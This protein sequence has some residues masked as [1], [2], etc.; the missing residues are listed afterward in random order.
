MPRVSIIITS[1]NCEN[2][3]EETIASAVAQSDV[4]LEVIVIDDAST[5]GTLQLALEAAGRDARVKVYPQAHGGKASIARNAG[6]ELAQGDY[7]CFLDGDDLYDPS[8]V[9]SQ[10]KFLDANPGTAAVFHDMKL[11]DESSEVI[12]PSFLQKYRFLE[13]AHAYL[14][15]LTA[16]T[17]VC[18]PQFY[19][20]MALEHSSVHTSSIMLRRSILLQTRLRFEEDVRMAEDI[21]F[22]WAVAR[23]RTLGYIDRQLSSYRVHGGNMTKNTETLLRDSIIVHRRNLARC[24]AALTPDQERQY[25]RKIADTWFS[26]GYFCFCNG[27]T[28]E[29]RRFYLS[30]IR[31]SFERRFAISYLKT[32]APQALRGAWQRMTTT[33]SSQ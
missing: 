22:W 12:A 25:E 5:D 1:F 11:I 19:L 21:E 2:Y 17:Y 18:N 33:P 29:A 27:R 32:L 14:T 7:I 10:R 9:E 6:L 31:L 28:R 24:A 26:L 23:G 3:I 8:K 13:K 30:A 4:D 15:K 16:D 20:Y